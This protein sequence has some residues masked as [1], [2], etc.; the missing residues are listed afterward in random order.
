MSARG[1]WHGE[2]CSG[3]AA[4]ARVGGGFSWWN[5]LLS[6]MMR[7]CACDADFG[8]QR[9][10]RRIIYS[11]YVLKAE[12]AGQFDGGSDEELAK[13]TVLRYTIN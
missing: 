11:K 3:D 6:A 9:R 12:A 8:S 5:N 2:V 13:S 1:G 10:L 4:G 7:K